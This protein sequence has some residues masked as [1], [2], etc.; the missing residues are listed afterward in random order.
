VQRSEAGHCVAFLCEEKIIWYRYLAERYIYF[1]ML[2]VT[3]PFSF[4][5]TPL[6]QTCD[7]TCCAKYIK[8]VFTTYYLESDRL[9][10]F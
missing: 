3:K 5:F 10:K 8:Q 7:I 1:K 9:G 4:S 6:P 2:P